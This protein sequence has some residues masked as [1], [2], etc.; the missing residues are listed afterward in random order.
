MTDVIAHRGASRAER[1]NT[2][3]AFRLAVALGA[4]G[5][6]L[7]VRPTAD[8]VLV[9]HHD[10][11]LDD[12]RAIVETPAADL[13]AHVPEL[14]AAL[15]AC[16]D[17][18]VNLEVKNDPTDPDFDPEDRRAAA[19]VELLARRAEP[20]Q[21]WLLSSFR[22]ETIDRIRDLAPDLATA[23][24]TMAA[25]AAAIERCRDHG[26]GTW[27]PWVG[28]VDAEAVAAA[29]AAGLRVNVWTCN[30]AEQANRLMAWGVDGIVT[31]VPDLM[32]SARALATPG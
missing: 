18:V 3:E 24:L 7:D 17:V 13:P 32:V 10:A 6:E 2:L 20:R 19:V 16:R 26:H 12:G 5:I 8:G 11:R 31:D 9:V 15:D 1:E 25:D 28:A 22:L 30:D 27:H 14:G 4:D 21:R 23:F 29:H